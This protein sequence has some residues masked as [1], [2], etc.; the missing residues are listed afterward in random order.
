MILG[1]CPAIGLAELEQG[2]VGKAPVAV[3][4]GGGK[5]AR[6]QAR[7][8]HRKL[9]RDRIAQGELRGP[10]A[11]QRGL[12]GRNER[13]GHRLDQP[14]CGKHPPRPPFPRLRFGQH[15]ARDACQARQRR[16]RHRVDADEA[17]HLL[18]EIDRD[19]DVRAPGW[20]RRLQLWRRA[21]KPDAERGEEALDVARLQIEAAQPADEPRIEGERR[22]RLRR[23]AGDRHLARGAAA[24]VEHHACRELEPR[25][26]EVGIDAA[27]EA[28]AGI[29][30]DVEPPPRPCRALRIEIRG[31]DEDVAGPL[32]GAG[33][34]AAK[35]AAKPEHPAV[36]GD[37][38]HIGIDRIALAV[39]AFERLAPLAEPGSDRALDLVGVVDVKRAAAVVRDVVGDIDQRVDRPEPDR[40]Q[41]TL[42]PLGARSVPD[43]A[44]DAAGE[45][46]AGVGAPLVEIELDRN[47]IGEAP[48]HRLDR[49]G[50]QPAET[51]RGEVTGD[52]A[53]AEAVGPVRRDG[54]IEHDVVETERLRRWA[55][56]LG[57]LGKLDDA[58]MLV[59][60][61]QL[62]LRQHH[63]ARIPRP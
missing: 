13:P 32:G 54:D 22:V 40:L 6:K 30:L 29:G 25:H 50:L 26:D 63:A 41:A 23:L 18:G 9:G 55:P 12:L 49:I 35:H 31:L 47:R 33:V 3:A 17:D 45:D 60:Q 46:R 51:G 5:E 1:L 34:L 61:L 38:A 48:R 62:A 11:E 8:H 7:P 20:G 36:V 28:V 21:R 42:Q 16:R 10:A 43:A 44:N 14:A 27:L 58:G 19:R 59:G 53:D 39:E 57:A 2:A 37:D 24:Q 4:L 56:D 52:A 15:R